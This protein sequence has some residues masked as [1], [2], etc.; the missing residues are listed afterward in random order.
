MQS[1]GPGASHIG[2]G[3]HRHLHQHRVGR[4]ATKKRSASRGG[5]AHNGPGADPGDGHGAA[6][7]HACAA[8]APSEPAPAAH[9]RPA[10]VPDRPD[11]TAGTAAGSL[12]AAPAWVGRYQRLT[13]RRA[14]T[15]RP[16]NKPAAAA[17]APPRSD[18]WP[19]RLSNRQK[20]K[21]IESSYEFSLE[22]PWSSH[23]PLHLQRARP[24]ADVGVGVKFVARRKRCWPSAD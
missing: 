18:R 22:N 24:P 23:L 4:T 6:N 2:R 21:R 14:R 7:R 8:V 16:T 12:A 20:Q 13:G 9:S 10:V 19:A 3:T 15:S 11:A 1:K 17:R 5:H